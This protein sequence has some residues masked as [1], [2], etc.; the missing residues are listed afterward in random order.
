MS[1]SGQHIPIPEEYAR[2]PGAGRGPKGERRIVTILFSDVKGS[3]AMAEALDPED[4]AEIMGEAFQYLVAP[5]RRY[6]GTVA[7]LMGDAIL[8]FFGAPEA[9]EDDPQRAILAGLEI[10]R[11][12]GP[13][14]EKVRQQYGLEFNVRV[15]INTGP[16]VVGDVGSDLAMEYTAMGDAVNVAAYM[17]QSA[18]PGTVQVAEATHRLVAPLFDFEDLG[19]LQVKG[20]RGPVRSY[21]VLAPRAEPGR[22][23]GIEGLSSPLI[24]RERE[25]AEL[26]RALQELRQ[27]R[28]GIVM[29]LGEAGLGKSRLLEEARQEFEA[30]P[31][32]R[33]LKSGGISYDMARPYS[34][35]QQLFRR[36]CNIS[37]HDEPAQARDR[38]VDMCRDFQEEVTAEAARAA[39]LILSLHRGSEAS[40]P[41]GEA[42]KRE[43]FAV[44]LAAW[45]K[46]AQLPLVLVFDD[47][48]WADP[49]SIE[50]L[51]HLFQLTDEIPLLFLCAMRPHRQSPGWAAK[52]AAE[53]SFPH[54]CIQIEL[55]PLSASESESLVDHL[56]DIAELPPALR[57]TIQDKGEGN[58][59]FVEEIIRTL[60]D[61]GAIEHDAESGHWR[62]T[63]SIESIALPDN[64]QALL[65]A[66]MDRL[67]KDVRRTLQLASVIGRSFFYR[68]LHWIAEVQDSLQGHLN[69]LQRVELIRE[70]ARAPEWEFMFRHDLT[71]DAAY[72]SILKRE[73]REFHRKVGEAMQAL[74]PERLEEEAHRLAYHFR[75][76][77]ELSRALDY[78][79]KA[80]DA[81]ARLYAN[82]E[83]ITHYG[84]AI[85]IA[86]KHGA[87]DDQL[88]H[89][90]TR[91]GRA[92]EVSGQF[93]QAL[94]TYA[95]LERLGAEQGKPLL[96]LAALLPQATVFSV[97][98]ARWD[99]AR[100]EAV[101]SRA[102]ELARRLD[103][104]RSESRALWN[105]MLV[106]NY[107]ERDQRRGI[108]HGE[109][110]LE[111]AR[112][113]GLLEE[114]AYALHD[115]SRAYLQMGR[116]P[117]GTAALEQARQ[118]WRQL[119]NLPLLADNL[120]SSAMPYYHGGDLARARSLTE[121]ALE[122][123][124]KIDN[125]W[126]QA[127]ALMALGII[128]LDTGEIAS[129]IQSLEECLRVSLQANF[130]GGSSFAP[131]Y[132][133]WV[134]AL[135]GDP[136]RALHWAERALQST[137]RQDPARVF[138]LG[139]KAVI[140]ARQ[141]Q[142]A[143]AERTLQ[144]IDISADH[145][146]PDPIFAG[147]SA[148]LDSELALARGHL[149]RALSVAEQGIDRLS[150][151][152][153]RTIVPNLQ[154]GRARALR[155]LGRLEQARS[156]LQEGRR[157][158]AETG[159]RLTLMEL[160][161][162]SHNLEH[163]AGATAAAQELAA[164]ARQLVTY[165]AERI[166]E[167]QLKQ[168]FLALPAVQAVA[169]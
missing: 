17:E 134:L 147:W 32:G 90:Y 149:E 26:R 84:H 112:R 137:D 60:I 72:H 22:L 2:T 165:I 43:L 13:F 74:F 154:L 59:F 92:H 85:E 91:V 18:Q 78:Y 104:P 42:L 52:A 113:H 130:V 168:S 56:L 16:V 127:Y 125:G 77:G 145:A 50:L 109:Q 68:V 24:G 148:S 162:E 88:I 122:I 21:R 25:L 39:E 155:Q 116:M 81:A 106:E 153:V 51:Q 8:A 5:I 103:D 101:A 119:G 120:V 110:A 136:T 100:G 126:G 28:G 49:A 133:A 140:L 80:G 36:L 111:I 107:L 11:E 99:A 169:G 83:A 139:I 65:I 160:L 40:A 86:R 96:E 89:L 35:F 157:L 9:H 53:T 44:M 131:S 33:W 161:L 64:L 66:R 163:S 70:V 61:A 58:P 142:L 79:S 118:L 150:R 67:E 151:L 97:P 20:K 10:L 31:G 3:S 138:P 54:R 144:R 71:R 159:A 63:Q 152:D 47:L 75:E 117:E 124:R 166:A 62:A 23:R 167:P 4:W 46:P 94:A 114:Q 108:Q 7:R 132:L 12:L 48:H 34:V 156:A 38:I 6:E 76:A 55:H 69:T 158:A 121:E 27:G 87:S 105:L 30:T 41:E 45:R 102:L 141:G 115:L 135:L 1:E 143:E 129:G 146:F 73:R 128:Q 98:S 82:Q 29:M 95:E 37:E 14:C 123:S 164:E 19:P 57:A 93:D 15:G